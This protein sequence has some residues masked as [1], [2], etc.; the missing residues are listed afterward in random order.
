M[1]LI[2]VVRK[3]VGPIEPVGETHTD[4][5]RFENLKVMTALVDQ[6]L[7]DIDYVVAFK[8]SGA[9]S[10]KRAGEYASKFQDSVGITE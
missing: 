1:E 9:F 8:Q 7:T 3:L 6:L 5:K 10:M 2:D 4:D